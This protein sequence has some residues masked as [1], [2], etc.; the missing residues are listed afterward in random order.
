MGELRKW[1]PVDLSYEVE[2]HKWLPV[3]LSYEV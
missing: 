3:D 1:L 2:L